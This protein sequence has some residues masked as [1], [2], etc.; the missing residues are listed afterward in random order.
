MFGKFLNSTNVGLKLYGVVY[1][2]E[3]EN[4]LVKKINLLEETKEKL[5]CKVLQNLV[6]K[7]TI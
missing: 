1:D 3:N 6:M 4:F 7:K 5:E 2:K